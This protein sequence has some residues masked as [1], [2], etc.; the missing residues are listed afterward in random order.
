MQ[1]AS[2]VF[3]VPV[4]WPPCGTSFQVSVLVAVVLYHT[5]SHTSVLT[6]NVPENEDQLWSNLQMQLMLNSNKSLWLQSYR[7]QAL[8]IQLFLFVVIPGGTIKGLRNLYHFASC[9]LNLTV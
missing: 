1:S 2:V 8:K 4:S 6:R 3:S 9:V 7:D 5:L